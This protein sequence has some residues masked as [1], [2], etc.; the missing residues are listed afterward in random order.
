MTANSLA[1]PCFLIL[2]ALLLGC[3]NGDSDGEPLPGE[4]PAPKSS[5]LLFPKKDEACYQGDVIS[6][7]QTRVR[8]EWEPSAHTDNYI[9]VLK[10]LATDEV[11]EHQ[12]SDTSIA[13]TILRNTPY[14]W[15]VISN[16]NQ[17]PTK[18]SSET[19]KFYS[20]GEGEDN[21]APFPAD[22]T[23]PSM[24]SSVPSPVTLSWKGSDVDDDIAS[25]DL[26]LDTNNPPSQ[27][28]ANTSNTSIK[29]IALKSGTVYYWSV[30]TKDK[31]GSSSRSPVFEFKIE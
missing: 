28:L 15:S 20:S 21:Y 22:I 3:S 31:N 7:T 6:P 23:A 24:G 11:S 5:V 19:W 29:G 2:S 25:Y 8:F 4:A 1:K 12:T 10:N 17:S 18:A 14:S 30:I 9:L 26:Y 13:L 27:F 16:S